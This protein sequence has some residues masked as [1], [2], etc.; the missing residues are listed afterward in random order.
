[1]TP[2]K[3]ASPRRALVTGAASG[4]GRA[5]ALCLAE[6]GYEL[7]LVDRDADGLTDVARQA[8]DCVLAV[9][10]DLAAP[11]QAAETV[12]A[13]SDE[14]PYDVLVNCAGLAFAA[15]ASE[16]TSDMWDLTMAVNLSGTFFMCRTVLPGMIAAGKGVIVNI[17]SAGGV[18][19]LR[20]RAAYCASKAGVIGLTRALAADHA[21]QGIRINAICPGTVDS[22]WIGKILANNPDPVTTRKAMEARQLD[23][24]MGTPEE[25]AEWI[26]F[27]VDDTGRFMNGASLI[28]DGGMTAV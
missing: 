17:A 8:G 10:A 3:I 20:N 14:R 7:T 22:P 6:A 21:G 12:Q 19:G 9:V 18:V 16:T 4:I 24:R 23:G 5:V 2:A 25:V 15:T 13:A 26:A 1:M 28:I 11:E 27:I